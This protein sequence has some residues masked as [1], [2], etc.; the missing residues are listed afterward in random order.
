MRLVI[1]TPEKSGDALQAMADSK[2]LKNAWVAHDPANIQK[3]STRNIYQGFTHAPGGQWRQVSARDLPTMAHEMGRQSQYRLAQP[4]DGDDKLLSLWWAVERQTP[5]ALKA[6]AKAGK[7][8]SESARPYAELLAAVEAHYLAEYEALSEVEPSLTNIE[9]LEGIIAT[10]DGI[11][12]KE[13]EKLLKTWMRDREMKKELIARK[14]YRQAQLMLKSNKS[15]DQ[16]HG[17]VLL[18]KI[19]AKY[20]ETVYGQRAAK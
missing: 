19:A 15:K 18:K 1:V 4:A 5:G 9:K 17:Q 7:S 10:Y 16:E 3:I 13:A 8:R 12:T 20:P 6:L 11:K 14:A 2:G